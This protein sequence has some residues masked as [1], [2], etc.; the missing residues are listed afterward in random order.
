M[1]SADG[2]SAK[3]DSAISAQVSDSNDSAEMVD[4]GLN[5]LL[6]AL[7]GALTLTFLSN[8]TTVLFTLT[9]YVLNRPRRLDLR[10]QQHFRADT[11]SAAG[12]HRF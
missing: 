2:P 8:G 11:K 9:G 3:L 7:E 5:L 4:I 12:H 6:A 1:Q 10:L